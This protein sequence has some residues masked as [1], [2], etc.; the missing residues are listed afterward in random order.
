MKIFLSHTFG[1][2]NKGDVTVLKSLLGQ[3]N[4]IPN[5]KVNFQYTRPR[6]IIV[7]R[8][9]EF[10]NSLKADIILFATRDDLSVTYGFPLD[11]FYE[12]SLAIILRKPSMLLAAQ[13]GPFSDDF[14][15]KLASSLT[16]ILLNR[17][18]LITVRDEFSKQELI[19]M[20]VTKPSIYVTADPGFLLDAVSYDK[21]KMFLSEFDIPQKEKIIGINISARAYHY[22]FP[23]IESSNKKYLMYVD[24]MVHIVEW[25]ICE[26]GA[27]VILVPHVFQPGDDDRKIIKTI[28]DR[29]TDKEKVHLITEELEPEELKGIISLFDM[30][31]TTRFHPLVHATSMEVPTIAIDYTFKMRNLMEELD[32]SD[33]LFHIKNINFNDFVFKVGQ[34]WAIRE[35]VRKKLKV[36]A[37][38]LRKRSELNIELIKRFIVSHDSI[39]Q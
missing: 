5:V 27:I 6:E 28:Y 20:G 8:W 3:L 31:I 11:I 21:A 17:I 1:K 30:F 13:I 37:K 14:K 12:I 33:W 4:K 38:I 24:L 10:V 25:I 22:S 9:L 16:S 39:E 18:E 2:H 19:R 34:L 23:T 35:E 32:C 26:L 15:G 29:V 36:R 7:E